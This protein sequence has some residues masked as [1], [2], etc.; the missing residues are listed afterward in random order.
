MLLKFT[1]SMIRKGNI[2]VLLKCYRKRNTKIIFPLQKRTASSIQLSLL[3]STSN[4]PSLAST[5]KERLRSSYGPPLSYR[6]S[7]VSVPTLEQHAS[8]VITRKLISYEGS[9]LWRLCQTSSYMSKVV[10]FLP[11]NLHKTLQPVLT[12]NILL[13]SRQNMYIYIYIYTFSSKC[14]ANP[15]FNNLYT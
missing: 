5:H 4:H 6:F 1:D 13:F 12:H 14:S 9:Q 15:D 7:L 2:D 3:I 11:W 10:L 8:R